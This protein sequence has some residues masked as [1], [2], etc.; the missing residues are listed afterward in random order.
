MAD[1]N[2]YWSANGQTGKLW[3]QFRIRIEEDEVAY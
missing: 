1:I 2:Y 3:R